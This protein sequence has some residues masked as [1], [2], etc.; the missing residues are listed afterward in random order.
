VDLKYDKF[1][2]G[3][4]WTT[5]L[6]LA[7][8][9]WFDIRFNFNIFLRD[10][11]R[12]LA[13]IQ[14]STDVINI[15]FYVSLF[16]FAIILPIGLYYISRPFRKIKLESSE[17]RVQSLDNNKQ[18][19]LSTSHSATSSLARPPSLSVPAHLRE[20]QNPT[21]HISVPVPTT[22]IATPVAPVTPTPTV[23]APNVVNIDDM[24]NVI[25]NAGYY[26]QNTA[27]IDGQ[28]VDIIAT[29]TGEVLLVCAF[30]VNDSDLAGIESAIRT[31]ISETLDA[32]VVVKIHTFNSKDKLATW[33]ADNKNPQPNDVEEFEAFTEYVNSITEYL[34]K[35][36]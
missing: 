3:I 31:I 22:P 8:D 23:A 16:V 12:F 28:Q 21:E 10:H 36:V 18:A 32:S 35:K 14:T 30:A 2:L 6:L 13:D 29:G 17:F 34:N 15:W 25:S 33:I 11:W 24:K 1:L 20:L 19:E 7:A 9:F 27:R 4:L 26:L 5:A